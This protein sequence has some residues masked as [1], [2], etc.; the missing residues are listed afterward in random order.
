MTDTTDKKPKLTDFDKKIRRAE[1]SKI[2]KQKKAAAKQNLSF[3]DYILKLES[4]KKTPEEIRII[5]NK[6]SRDSKARKRATL[7]NGSVGDI[8]DSV[9]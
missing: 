1:Q 6:Q 2:C 5:R 9:N 3:G 8:V 4:S 7:K